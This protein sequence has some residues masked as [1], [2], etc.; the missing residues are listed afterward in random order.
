VFV[1][2]Y[3]CQTTQPLTV[4]TGQ[5]VVERNVPLL[6]HGELDDEQLKK[7]EFACLMTFSL[8]HFQFSSDTCIGY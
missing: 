1:L 7:T 4:I 3:D 8:L 5:A 6:I 2:F